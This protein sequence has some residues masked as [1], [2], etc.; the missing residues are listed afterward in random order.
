MAG[1]QGKGGKVVAEPAGEPLPLLSDHD[2]RL[3]IQGERVELERSP[4]A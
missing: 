2:E 3:S 1:S 4:P